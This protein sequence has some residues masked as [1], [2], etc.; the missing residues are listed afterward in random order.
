MKMLFSYNA[1]LVQFDRCGTCRRKGRRLFTILLI[2]INGDPSGSETV[3]EKN[4]AMGADSASD[5]EIIVSDG[6]QTNRMAFTT[7]M[8]FSKST[9]KLE[10]YNYRYTTGNSGDSY[11]V[12]IKKNQ[13]T[14]TLNRGGH[15]SEVTDSIS[16]EYG[17][18]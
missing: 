9:G 18:S 14:R 17:D 7:K 8:V 3:V 10:F 2:L 15:T 4:A 6:I 12:A 5:H 13:I 16:A 11:E 1:L